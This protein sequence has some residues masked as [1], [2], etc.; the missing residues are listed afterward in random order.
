[1]LP[2]YPLLRGVSLRELREKIGWTSG[3]GALREAMAGLVG[4]FA[5]LPL[6]LLSLIVTV[7]IVVARSAWKVMSGGEEPTAPTNPILDVVASGNI[8]T[9]C[10]FFSLAT[11]WAPFVEESIFRGALFRH[12]RG[13][14]GVFASAA[15][16]A[17]VFGVLHGYEFTMLL[18]VVTLGFNFALV[19]NWRGSLIGPMVA[20]ALHNATVL[21]LVIA[22]MSIIAP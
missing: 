5:G 4:Y 10:L 3:R 6:V 20:H 2:L 19:R 22:L 21:G 1:V 16:S 8:L 15:L 18:P 9:L 11:L 14:W 13:S 17:V 7:I 12:V